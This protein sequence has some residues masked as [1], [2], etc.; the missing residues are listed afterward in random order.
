[1]KKLSEITSK[2]QYVLDILGERLTVSSYNAR[3]MRDM[4]LDGKNIREFFAEAEIFPTTTSVMFLWY[5][6]TAESKQFFDNNIEA[7]FESLGQQE[8]DKVGM[9]VTR[10][11]EDGQPAGKKLEDAT[12]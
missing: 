9:L 4:E 5:L 11:Y 6:L 7:L 10:I 8:L 1:M 2:N 12:A 3:V